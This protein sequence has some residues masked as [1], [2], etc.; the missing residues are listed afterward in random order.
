LLAALIPSPS[1]L[2]LVIP[3]TLWLFIVAIVMLS[4]GRAAVDSYAPST[5]FLAAISER[6]PSLA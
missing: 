6:A 4:I 1:G 5:P 3:A 2:P